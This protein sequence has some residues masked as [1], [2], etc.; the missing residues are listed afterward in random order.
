MVHLLFGPA[1]KNCGALRGCLCHR[2]GLNPHV[3]DPTAQHPLP[4]CLAQLPAHPVDHGPRVERCGVQPHPLRAF[5]ALG[6]ELDPQLGAHELFDT[7]PRDER[8]GGDAHAEGHLLGD[9]ERWLERDLTLQL[10]WGRA[11]IDRSR[12]VPGGEIVQADA[13]ITKPLVHSLGVQARKIAEAVHA[14]PREQLDQLGCGREPGVGEH[15][16]RQRRKKRWSLPRG[17][18]RDLG[19]EL[20]EHS[21]ACSLLG[22]EGAIG[23]ARAHALDAVR[24]EHLDELDRRLRFSPVV[25]GD[26]PGPERA[27]PRPNDLHPRG[28]LFDHRDCGGKH[29]VIARRIGGDDAQLRAS[30]LRVS[31]PLPAP[32]PLGTR[33][34]RASDDHVVCDERDRWRE[35]PHPLGRGSGSRH[36]S[37]RH[38]RHP[39]HRG[40]FRPRGFS[41]QRGDRPIRKPQHEAAHR[42]LCLRLRLRHQLTARTLRGSASPRRG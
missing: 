41:Q 3:R 2:R 34:G 16:D 21:P 17:H 7:E 10:G 40:G 15:R 6:R 9:L 33:R 14:E 35:R 24:G 32:H 28:A 18:D 38:H 25:A 23:N 1:A 42:C 31:S 19:V 27:D 5:A 8:F 26:P 20:A 37:R 22:G 39:H 4:L 13:A 30:R 12:V 11:W 29:A 36:S